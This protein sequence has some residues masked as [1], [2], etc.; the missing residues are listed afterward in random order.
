MKT[1]KLSLLLVLN[2]FSS[3]IF[4]Q[5]LCKLKILENNEIKLLLYFEGEKTKTETTLIKA[6]EREFTDREQR[7]NYLMSRIEQTLR[8]LQRTDN[9]NDTSKSY[10]EVINFNRYQE[11]LETRDRIDLLVKNIDSKNYKSI[12]KNW[13]SE[14]ITALDSNNIILKVNVSP[15]PNKN[16]LEYQFFL[17]KPPKNSSDM[18]PLSSRYCSSSAII[19][20]SEI[21][22]YYGLIENAIKRLF[23][24]SNIP[25]T[26]RVRVTYDLSEKPLRNIII[27]TTDAN[28]TLFVAQGDTVILDASLSTDPDSRDEYIQ[29]QWKLDAS[30]DSQSIILAKE[31]S[32]Q[33]IVFDSLGKYSFLVRVDDNI[34]YDILRFHIEVKKKPIFAVNPRRISLN[35][36]NSIQGLRRKRKRGK[37]IHDRCFNYSL[38]M[39]QGNSQ[40]IPLKEAIKYDIDT[41]LIKLVT[42]T[43]KRDTTFNRIKV[44]GNLWKPG[45]YII[46]VYL[47]K[48]SVYSKKDTILLAYQSRGLFSAG[49]YTDYILIE[50]ELPEGEVLGYFDPNFFLETNIFS[51]VSLELSVSNM[52]RRPNRARDTIL[53]S[54]LFIR[55]KVRWGARLKFDLLYFVPQI[56]RSNKFNLL[57]GFKRFKIGTIKEPRDIQKGIWTI[58]YEYRHYLTKFKRRIRF[59]VPDIGFL[60]G[61]ELAIRDKDFFDFY[62]I[63]FGFFIQ[64]VLRR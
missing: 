49:I 54:N 34:E 52:I 53:I 57:L 31:S 64:N 45:E 1:Y 42:D 11:V 63:R 30:P 36:P 27:D 7:M 43:V 22:K 14:N 3:N 60:F 9:S 10:L 48:D 19:S 61:A 32:E 40:D 15:T 47:K 6:E 16:F 8:T 59:E 58:G 26:P 12:F 17:Y 4:S 2:L 39:Y 28:T 56:N 13:P 38:N 62:N 51:S 44:K 33:T 55:N 18:T 37:G 20:P 5:T 50:D 29:Y 23:P 35:R 24:H 41:S 46:P 25:P 21:D